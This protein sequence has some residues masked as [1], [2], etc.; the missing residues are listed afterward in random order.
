MCYHCTTVAPAICKKLLTFPHGV[1][2]SLLQTFESGSDSPTT[3][4][5]APTVASKAKISNMT[6][7]LKV[8]NQGDTKSSQ[9]RMSLDYPKGGPQWPSG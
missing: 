9:N 7:D 1:G 8:L 2:P 6:L 4:L 5:R 3:T